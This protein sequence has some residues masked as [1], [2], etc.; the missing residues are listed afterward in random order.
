MLLLVFLIVI[1]LTGRAF[2]SEENQPHIGNFGLAGL[3]NLPTAK[4]FP[5]GELIATHQNHKFLF[6]NGVSFQALPRVGVSFRYGG[7]GRGGQFAQSRVNWD[8]SFDIQFALLDERKYLPAISVGLRDFIGTGWYSSEYIVG[9]KT[10]GNLE[11]TA[12]LGFGRLAG[13]NAVSNPLGKLSSN[14]AE[15]GGKKWGKGGTLGNINWFQGDTSIFYGANYRIVK[16]IT[17]SSE[18]SPDL[19]SREISYLNL[20]SPEPWS[21]L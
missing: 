13:R 3:I 20:E 6:M 12:G 19:M 17:L 21:I 9:T 5:D 15:R 16:K 2:A 8:R 14:F 18:Y 7:Q 1:S 11:I 10:F 4:R